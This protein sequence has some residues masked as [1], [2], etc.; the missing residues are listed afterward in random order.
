MANGD[1]A[2]IDSSMIIDRGEMGY[3]VMDTNSGTVFASASFKAGEF[4]LS[5]FAPGLTMECSSSG[6]WFLYFDDSLYTNSLTSADYQIQQ[7]GEKFIPD[8]IARKKDL[9]EA[10]SLLDSTLAFAIGSGVIV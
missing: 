4:D 8:T 1:T 6:L 5:I 2:I 3:I 10:I 7:L 9:D